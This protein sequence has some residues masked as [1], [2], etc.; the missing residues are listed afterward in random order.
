MVP[1]CMKGKLVKSLGREDFKFLIFVEQLEYLFSAFLI[2]YFSSLLSSFAAF[3]K[4]ELIKKNALNPEAKTLFS[5]VKEELRY[6]NHYLRI[7]KGATNKPSKTP[8]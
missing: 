3:L 1:T 2:E 5:C 7:N 4:V 6:Q 8:P